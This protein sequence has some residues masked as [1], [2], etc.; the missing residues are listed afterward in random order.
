MHLQ[1]L[2]VPQPGNTNKQTNKQ[3]KGH[4]VNTT[5]HQH[6]KGKKQ[7]NVIQV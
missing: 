1:V 3:R 2:N 7:S 4:T 6:S 5:R